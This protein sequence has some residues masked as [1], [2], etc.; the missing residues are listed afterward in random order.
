MDRSGEADGADWM[1]SLGEWTF[2]LAVAPG[3]PGSPGSPDCFPSS[4]LLR[5]IC[6]DLT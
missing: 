1:A 5:T 3:S 4:R 6:M 2:W